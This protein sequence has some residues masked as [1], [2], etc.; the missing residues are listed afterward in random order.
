MRLKKQGSHLRLFH[1]YTQLY[2][3]STSSEAIALDALW[4]IEF[5]FFRCWQVVSVAYN[6]I[7]S[8]VNISSFL[9]NN[10]CSRRA[11][12][13]VYM[14]ALEALWAYMGP[15]FML[16][17]SICV[18]YSNVTCIYPVSCLV[19]IKLFQMQLMQ[20][21]RPSGEGGRFLIFRLFKFIFFLL[22]E[23]HGTFFHILLNATIFCLLLL[24]FD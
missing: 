4:F 21:P 10:Y 16:L 19:E 12:H 23:F 18:L 9:L 22:I 20:H 15:H 1:I 24:Y 13:N 5:L 6:L 11:G 3:R 8:M 2:V 17:L 7:N 14:Y